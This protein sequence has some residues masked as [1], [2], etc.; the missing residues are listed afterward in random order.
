MAEPHRCLSCSKPI[1]WSFAIC[2]KCETIYGSRPSHWPDWLAYLWREEQRERRRN[3]R[4][5]RFEICF[6]DVYANFVEGNRI[7]D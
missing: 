6:S 2:R 4:I 5:N 1:S 7:D 3:R